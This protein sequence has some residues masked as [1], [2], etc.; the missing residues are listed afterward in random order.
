MQD[1]YVPKAKHERDFYWP[2]SHPFSVTPLIL[3]VIHR[4]GE[5]IGDLMKHH[6]SDIIMEGSFWQRLCGPQVGGQNENV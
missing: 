1:G 3:A 4:D 2:D 5:M 6:R